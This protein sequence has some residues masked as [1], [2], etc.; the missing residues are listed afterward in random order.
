MRA[1]NRRTVRLL[2]GA[3]FNLGRSPAKRAP[4]FPASSSRNEERENETKRGS[5][6]RRAP[7]R[8]RRARPSIRGAGTR[9]ARAERAPASLPRAAR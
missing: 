4:P 1:P 9:G 6:E 7:V 5:L 8:V 2:R 3:V